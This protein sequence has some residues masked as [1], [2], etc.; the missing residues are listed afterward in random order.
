MWSGSRLGC[1]FITI[2]PL[3]PEDLAFRLVGTAESAAEVTASATVART[4]GG[5]RVAPSVL[6]R[7][8]GRPLVTHSDRTNWRATT[9]DGTGRGVRSRL[10]GTPRGRPRE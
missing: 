1:R 6:E 2:W 10:R 3:L 5:G 4:T 7:R 9:D 8:A